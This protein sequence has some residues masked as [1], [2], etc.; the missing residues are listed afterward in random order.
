L[1]GDCDAVVFLLAN[2]TL[3]YASLFVLRKREPQMNRAYA[4]GV[5][6]GRPESPGRFHFVLDCLDRHGPRE[7]TPS[8]GHA[9]FE[10][11]RLS[12]FEVVTHAPMTARQNLLAHFFSDGLALHKQQQ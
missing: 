8:A 6:P 11:S 9:D 2:Y 5:I 4:R 10:L 12:G 3:T 1:N 7:R